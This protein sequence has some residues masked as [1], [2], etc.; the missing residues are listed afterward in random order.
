[1]EITSK[2][3]GPLPSLLLPPA[4]GPALFACR[5]QCC[6]SGRRFTAAAAPPPAEIFST[7]RPLPLPVQFLFPSGLSRTRHDYP[8]RPPAATSSSSWRAHHR[9][10]T[11]GLSRATASRQPL[12]PIAQVPEPICEHPT[13]ISP[14]P[15]SSAPATHG[16]PV[17]SHNQT[18][19]TPINPCA[20][21][22]VAQ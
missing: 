6:A 8:E 20:S 21:F 17:G 10:L 15:S 16:T 12:R 11:F 7:R 18:S 9:A 4:R 22:S 1:L 19:S 3:P 13:H 14:P 5:R 2:S